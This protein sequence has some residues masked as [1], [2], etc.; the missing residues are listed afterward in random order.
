MPETRV[1]EQPLTQLLQA[2]KQGDGVAFARLFDHA[3]AELKQVAARRIAQVAGNATLTPTELLHEVVV[4]AMDHTMTWQN[5]AHFFASMSVAM[6]SVLIDHARARLS[7]KR[8]QG[9]VHLTLGQAEVGDD[10]GIVDLLALDAALVQL[11][12]LDARSGAVLH[13]T[14]FAGL[15][16]HEIAEVLQVSVQVVDRELRFAKSW[17]NAHL[18]TRL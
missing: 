7:D 16:R 5:R 4:R 14:C 2:W 9:A 15:D 18:D 3:Y 13:L 17:L 11:S 8:G 1:S 12:Q 10:S 6:R